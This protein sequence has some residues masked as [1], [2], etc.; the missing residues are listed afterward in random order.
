MKLIFLLIAATTF[1]FAAAQEIKL[2]KGVQNS[3]E[4]SKEAI[5]VPSVRILDTPIVI[6]YEKDKKII[7]FKSSEEI[8]IKSIVAKG[9]LD[10][11]KESFFG[12]GIYF[13]IEINPDV[14][15]IFFRENNGDRYMIARGIEFKGIVFQKT[16]FEYFSKQAIPND[17]AENMN[18]LAQ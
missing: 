17:L 4:V 18:K 5:L 12:E 13:I 1:E 9:N 2:C 8:D 15:F 3:I 6:Y 10:P 16:D 7:N 11:E 14:I